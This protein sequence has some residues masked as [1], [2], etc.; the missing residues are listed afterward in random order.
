MPM[1]RSRVGRLAV[2]LAVQWMSLLGMGYV[3]SDGA[4]PWGDFLRVCAAPALC[5]IVTLPVVWAVTKKLNA[6]G[7]WPAAVGLAPVFAAM[8][9]A[10]YFAPAA[11]VD[12][13]SLLFGCLV[14]VLLA[15]GVVAERYE[16]ER[17]LEG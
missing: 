6:G 14:G 11:A 12:K 4:T 10:W 3:L 7:L 1:S 17:R 5:A 13:R 15:P 16:R 8:P 9:L 2:V